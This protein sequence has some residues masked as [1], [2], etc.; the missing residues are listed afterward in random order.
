MV[1]ALG[2]VRTSGGHTGT[3]GKETEMAQEKQ[4]RQEL[5]DLAPKKDPK[6]GAELRNTFWLGIPLAQKPGQKK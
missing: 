4:K 3:K 5:R 2:V 1:V 6:G